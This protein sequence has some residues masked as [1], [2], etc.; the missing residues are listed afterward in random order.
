MRL[1][2]R[3]NLLPSWAEL[4][5][6]ALTL[7]VIYLGSAIPPR[8]FPDLR[9]FDYD[10]LLH[11]TEYTGLGLALWVAG[12]RRWLGGLL[13]WTESPLLAL[14]LGVVAPGALWAASDELHQL[15]VGRDCSIWDW[16]ADLGGL[17]LSVLLVRLAERREAGRSIEA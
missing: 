5:V 14:L 7:A 9:I 6:L 12:R 15:A 2:A 3:L 17:L 11:L 1:L 13:K 16:L 8:D 4:V 10:K